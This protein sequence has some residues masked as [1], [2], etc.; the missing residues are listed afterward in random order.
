MTRRNLQTCAIIGLCFIAGMIVT[1]RVI[2]GLQQCAAYH[3]CPYATLA[4]GE[5]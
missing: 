3:A 1:D 4:G 2:A 5:R